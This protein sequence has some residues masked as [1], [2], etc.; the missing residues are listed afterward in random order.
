[1]LLCPLA[2]GIKRWC[3]LTSICLP[4]RLSETGTHLPTCEGWQAELAWAATT[5]S[6]LD[7]RP[8]GPGMLR[9]GYLGCC[10]KAELAWARSRLSQ[11]A[12][13][14]LQW[15][16]CESNPQPLGNDRFDLC[17]N[18][19]QAVRE[20]AKICLRPCKLTSD[21]L[22]LRVVFE[23]RNVGYLCANFSLPRPLFLST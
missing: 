15:T 17:L 11:L 23:S 16:G 3:C 20:A 2:G 7:S 4:I 6:V 19:K 1:M 18:F 12:H 10:K 22:T 21:I 9:D 13:G 8:V 14:C 5:V